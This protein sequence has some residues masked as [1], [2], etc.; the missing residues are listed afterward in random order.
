MYASR[1]FYRICAK[2]VDVSQKERMLEDV[3]KT[4]C[5]LEKELLPS[6]F[7]IMMY[8][9]IYLVEEIF[10]CGLV[11]MRW[12]YPFE[13]YMKGLKGFVTNKAKPEGSMAVVYL[14]EESI[15]F[16]NEYLS[17]YTPTTK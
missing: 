13:W 5:S 15:R 9:P 4:I 7:F 10:I 1:I 2:V 6:V 14:K 11:H 12:M 16:L 17:K 3:A 8:M